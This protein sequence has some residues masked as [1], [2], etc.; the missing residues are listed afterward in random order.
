M[1]KT[2]INPESLQAMLESASNAADKGQSQ[3]FT[4]VAFGQW[5]ASALPKTRL[6]LVDLTCGAGHLLQACANSTTTSLLGADIDPC[7]IASWEAPPASERAGP[8]LGAP[9]ISKIPR[10][11]TLLAP[12]L[13][14]IQFQA[15]CFV[16]NPPWRLY[17]HR[18]RLAHLQQSNCTAVRLALQATEDPY[19]GSCPIEAIDSTIATLAIALDL[20]TIYGEGFLIAN[21][22]TLQ[23]LLFEPGAPYAALAKH[24]WLHLRIPGNPMTGIDGCQ[25]Q[26]D[27]Q[28]YT[29]VLYFAANHTVGPQHRD[30]APD[31][32]AEQLAALRQYRQGAEV[33]NVHVATDAA[34]PWQTVKDHLAE[35][36]GRAPKT[37]WNLWLNV[38]GRIRTALSR[39]EERSTKVDKGEARRLFALTGKSP[40]ELVLQRAQRHELL[41]VAER[42]GWRIQ[43]ELLDAVHTAVQQY[44][45]ARAP[46][47]P[48]PEIQRLGYLDEQ[49]A[50]TCKTDLVR[51][52]S[53]CSALFRAGN[54]YPIRTQTVPVTRKVS[55]PNPQTGDDETLELSGQELAILLDV[56]GSEFC[57]MDALLMVDR[58]TV[59]PNV[60]RGGDGRGKRGD[61][62][63]DFS[64][65]ELCAH[66]IIP[67]VPDVATVNR[68]GYEQYLQTLQ[69]IELLT[70]N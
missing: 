19:Q 58:N 6:T 59:V 20:C 42:A 12:V 24:V 55:K 2:N 56:N 26:E 54:T 46:L 43:P 5:L 23:R 14:E 47:Y 61:S 34:A 37:P 69:E 36:N 30:L 15:D 1:Q 35:L 50:M 9:A 52:G 18:D 31:T 11:L 62:P 17:W 7:R 49:D 38:G 33:R 40:M 16:L 64:L 57:F 22:S 48:L 63:I 60:K 21:D 10:D 32:P 65:Q 53:G 13:K 67:E 8:P 44:H 4:P 28:F 25:W 41:H 68:N 3:F 27:T 51:A 39:F 66:F 29:G 70:S 45:A